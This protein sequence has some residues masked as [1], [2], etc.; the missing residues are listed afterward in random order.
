MPVNRQNLDR[1]MKRRS[2]ACEMASLMPREVVQ[3][4][5]KFSIVCCEKCNVSVRSVM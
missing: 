3:Q 5:D 4:A 1:F 2:E